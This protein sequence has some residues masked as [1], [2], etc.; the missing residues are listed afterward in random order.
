MN[1]IIGAGITGLSCGYFSKEPYIIFEKE[2]TV[3]GLCKS[4]KENGFTFDC[5]GHFLH[6]KNIKIKNLTEKLLGQKLLKIK[7]KSAILFKDKVIPFPFQTNLC[8]LDEKEKKECIE[9]IR[10]RK[11]IKIYNDMPFA[12]WAE[13][14]FGKGIT[15]YFMRPYNQKLWNCN[16]KQLTAAWTAPFVPKPSVKEIEQ[17]AY[18]KAKK[19]YGY[20]GIFY[21]P[22]SGGC[23]T[24]VN[25]F[26]KKVKNNV[27]LNTKTEKID[28]KNKRILAG[29]KYYFYDKL[30]STQPLRELLLQTENLPKNIS[31]LIKNLEYTTTRCINIGIKYR[32]DLPEILKNIHWLYVPEKKYP[33]YRVG[34]YSNISPFA[35]PKKCFGLYIET[36]DLNCNREN[37]ITV[38]KETGIIR[39]DDRILS[40][41]T[42]DMKYAYVI[43]N[44]ERNATLKAINKFLNEN[45]IFSIGRYGG[46]EYSFMERN[47]IDAKNI[48]G[49][50]K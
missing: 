10:N 9:G 32:K 39:D 11:N 21:Y 34:V 22:K 37:L 47:I 17:S 49:N 28:F 13:T 1:I 27:F 2:N 40:F 20:N 6:I 23:Q 31:S 45:N 35:A 48:Y 43:Y 26:Y 4:V 24:I 3:G 33:F 8:Y 16:L 46:W 25:G 19:E 36:T 38:L 18:K 42:I 15:K 41:N 14:T 12:E 50:I 5:S 30:I 29:G 7:R 44:K